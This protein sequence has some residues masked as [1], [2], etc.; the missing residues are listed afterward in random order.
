MEYVTA[1]LIDRLLKSTRLEARLEGGR[2][3]VAVNLGVKLLAALF[4]AG[5]LG[6]LFLVF[7]YGDD[8]QPLIIF[9]IIGAFLLLAATLVYMALLTHLEFDDNYI[10][11]SSPFYRNRRIPWSSVT[12]G[13][14]SAALTTYYVDTKEIGKIRISAMQHGWAEF[15]RLAGRKL[16]ENHGEDPFEPILPET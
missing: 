5:P 15:L 16:R 2:R 8:G 12:R 1:S 7:L 9:G 11:F 3:I 10:Y 4:P 14:Y 13:W 6:A